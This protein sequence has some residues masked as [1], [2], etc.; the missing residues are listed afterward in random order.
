MVRTGGSSDYCSHVEISGSR[1]ACRT[2]ERVNRGG[3]T[4]YA[5]LVFLRALS[6]CEWGTTLGPGRWSPTGSGRC[7]PERP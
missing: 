7:A 5:P 2:V 4:E 1:C 3:V 6:V